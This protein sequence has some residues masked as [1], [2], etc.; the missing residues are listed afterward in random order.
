MTGSEYGGD[1]KKVFSILC[2][3]SVKGIIDESE[4]VYDVTENRERAESIF[5]SLFRNTVTPRCLL[6]VLEDLLG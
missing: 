5:A 2:V 1:R 4:Y 3:K 6:E